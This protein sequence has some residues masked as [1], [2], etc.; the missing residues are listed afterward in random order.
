MFLN[1][2]FVLRE[3]FYLAIVVIGLSLILMFSFAFSF[4]IFIDVLRKFPPSRVWQ[5]KSKE[6][7]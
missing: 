4:P 6:E 2:G 5:V 1:I 3:I 7:G